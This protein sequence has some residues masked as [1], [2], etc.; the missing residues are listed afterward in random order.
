MFKLKEDKGKEMNDLEINP[1]QENR[2]Q[3]EEEKK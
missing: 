3:I 1:R 2:V